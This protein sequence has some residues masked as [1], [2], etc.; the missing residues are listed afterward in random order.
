MARVGVRASVVAKKGRNGLGAKGRREVERMT[1]QIRQKEPAAMP[2]RL[3]TSG[4]IRARWA[5]VEAEVWTEPMLTAL[6][7]GVQGGKWF[8]LHSL[9]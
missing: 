4:E 6:E 5:W 1:E 3:D 2:T 7:H 9:A 8:S